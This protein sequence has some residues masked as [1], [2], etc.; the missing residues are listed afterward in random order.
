MTGWA[1]L[2]RSRAAL[3]S[4]FLLL[5]CM[6][7]IPN[8]PV[9][10][11]TLQAPA[12]N[13]DPIEVSTVRLVDYREAAVAGALALVVSVMRLLMSV[14]AVSIRSRATIAAVAFAFALSAAFAALAIVL[15]RTLSDQARY[16]WQWFHAVCPLILLTPLPLLCYRGTHHSRDMEHDDA[17]SM[18]MSLLF[19]ELSA[20]GRLAFSAVWAPWLTLAAYLRAYDSIVFYLATIL[21]LEVGLTL[22]VAIRRRERAVLAPAFGGGCELHTGL[23]EG[24]KK[25]R[26][27]A[28][29]ASGVQMDAV[30]ADHCTFNVDSSSPLESR[31]PF[32]SSEEGYA[33]DFDTEFDARSFDVVL[34]GPAALSETAGPVLLSVPRAH[35]DV[36]STGRAPAPN[37]T[38]L[39]LDE[40]PKQDESLDAD[41]DCAVLE[42][43]EHV[44]GI[45]VTIASAFAPH[46]NSI[47]RSLTWDGALKLG[48][49]LSAHRLIAFETGGYF[50]SEEG[51]PRKSKG[52]EVSF[53]L[54]GAH[55]PRGI[56]YN[57]VR[58]RP[59]RSVDSDPGGLLEKLTDSMNDIDL[60][61]AKAAWDW[62]KS[63]MCEV[64]SSFSLFTSLWSTLDMVT[65]VHS[66]IEQQDRWYR[67]W[68]ASRNAARVVRDQVVAPQKVGLW[69]LSSRLGDVATQSGMNDILDESLAP[70]FVIPTPVLSILA[71]VVSVNGTSLKRILTCEN[72]DIV[73]AFRNSESGS[74]LLTTIGNLLWLSRFAIPKSETIEDEAA[75]VVLSREP[76]HDANSTANSNNAM[77][78]IL[79]GLRL[80]M[81]VY[82]AL[83]GASHMNVFMLALAHAVRP[84]QRI[85]DAHVG[86]SLY[87]VVTKDV[88][89]MDM[90]GS[91][92]SSL[93]GKLGSP[94]W[95]KKIDSRSGLAHDALRVL[96]V[97]RLALVALSSAGTLAALSL[98]AALV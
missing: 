45:Y 43:P 75:A 49:A 10:A 28:L 11:R 2:T 73:S 8:E 16:A 33:T 56:D 79:R 84:G 24:I 50:E 35:I 70:C 22:P 23:A 57:F 5:L 93:M 78:C 92:A 76:L 48:K 37:E 29:T 62:M 61:V 25:A 94:T 67:M 4:C 54:G 40:V 21:A 31:L 90:Y 7:L 89:M 69:R 52:E 30:P 83:D 44:C 19:Q 51:D 77:E 15:P 55:R 81:E 87:N 71:L 59:S 47:S 14:T 12:E 65:E 95:D 82:A 18:S 9:L 74:R 86:L 41:K 58:R 3:P 34:R 39:D 38:L 26:L 72:A 27:V 13:A 53:S 64:N 66:I 60:H 1:N 17:W 97:R 42:L 63:E 85:D 88:S 68:L 96:F 32:L 80:D 20:V 91:A 36:P 46:A 6:I 98:I